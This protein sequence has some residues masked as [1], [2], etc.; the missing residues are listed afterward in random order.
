MPGVG[1]LLPATA[2]TKLDNAQLDQ[3]MAPVA[4]YPDSLLSQILMG[5]TYPDD[6]AAAAKWSAAHTSESGDQ[7]VKAVEG[8]SWDPSVK[9][10]VAFP[11]VMDMMGRQPDWVK[12]VGDASWRSPTP[13]WIRSRGCAS[14][15]RRPAT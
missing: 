5:A 9:S 10:L 14:R 13:S 4:L 6:V 15:R 11:S 7:A 8:E 1:C 2:Q 12:S 3:L